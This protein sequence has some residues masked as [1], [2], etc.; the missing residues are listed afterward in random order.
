MRQAM[1][2]M[3]ALKVLLPCIGAWVCG[4]CTYLFEDTMKS[5]VGA[6]IEKFQ[7]QYKDDGELLSTTKDPGPDE[8]IYKYRIR[9]LGHCWVYWYV[10]PQGIIVRW[11]HEGRDCQAVWP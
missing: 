3:T 5:W 6:P 10:N 7:T 1:T 2:K 8:T 9:G 4:G 11:K